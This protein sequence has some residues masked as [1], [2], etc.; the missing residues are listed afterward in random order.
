MMAD[1]TV[2]NFSYSNVTHAHTKNLVCYR[3]HVYEVSK[4]VK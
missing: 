1:L 3:Q 4:L 2:R